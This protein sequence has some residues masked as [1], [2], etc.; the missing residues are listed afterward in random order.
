MHFWATNGGFFEFGQPSGWVSD[1]N[2]Q[3][4]RLS[5]DVAPEFGHSEHMSM[6]MLAQGL[7]TREQFELIKLLKLH[8]C[9]I[10][11]A[12]IVQG[13]VFKREWPS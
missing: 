12:I 10:D 7:T 4:N 11:Y 2:G 3:Q 13:T 1:V 9:I 6:L 5:K 8:V